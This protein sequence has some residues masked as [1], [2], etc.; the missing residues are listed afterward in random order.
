ME[1]T[2][3]D[4]PKEIIPIEKKDVSRRK[5]LQVVGIFTV[6]VGSGGLL[7]CEQQ[8]QRANGCDPGTDPDPENPGDPSAGVC[9]GY[10]LVDSRKCQGCLTCMA[11]CSLVNEGV[12][13][14]SL[15]RIQVSVDAF[16]KYPNDVLISQCRQCEDPKCIEA[17]PVGAMIRDPDHGNI[18]L[19]NPDLCIGCGRCIAACPFEPSRSFIAPDFDGKNKSRKCDL[20]LNAPYHFAPEGGGIDGKRTCESVCPMQAIQFTTLMPVQQGDDGY[21]V[22]LRNN[23][24]KQLGYDITL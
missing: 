16:G 19:V 8:N 18:R 4:N 11:A 10:I 5:F 2:K 13:G 21:E 1:N 7:A 12:A 22:N 20:C 6:S 15:A 17:C 3:D 23:K 14:I 24:W 9:M